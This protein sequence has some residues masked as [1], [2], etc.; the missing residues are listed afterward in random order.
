MSPYSAPEAA[1]RF[2]ASSANSSHVGVL[3]ANDS[4]SE[5]TMDGVSITRLW[6]KR[7]Q[8]LPKPK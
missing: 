4:S 8:W 2:S 5:R 7:W 3:M 1:T 6:G